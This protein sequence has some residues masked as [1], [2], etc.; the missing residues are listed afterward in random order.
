MNPADAEIVAAVRRLVLA[1]GRLGVE[2]FV[3]G[4]IASM[5]FGEPRLTLD[6]DIVARLRI[7]HAGPLVESLGSGFYADLHAIRTAIERH[8]SFNLIHLETMVKIDVYVAASTSFVESEFA[9]RLRRNVGPAAEPLELELASPEDV[10]LAKLEWFRR[11]GE[12]SDRQWRDILG[13]LKVQG[14]RL[15]LGYLRWWAADLH[16]EDLLRRALDD[17]GLGSG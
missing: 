8:R 5:V 17:A 12:V 14:D 1:L 9:R 6:A 7:E 11:G 2:Y 4:S 16:V 15:D 13:V 3:G 10:V